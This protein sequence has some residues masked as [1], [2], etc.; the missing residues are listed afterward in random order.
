MPPL[1]TP[2]AER[3]ASPLDQLRRRSASLA[4]LPVPGQGRTAER[5]NALW[6]LGYVEL[7]LGRL[8]EAHA[9]SHAI[10]REAGRADLA[11]VDGAAA[12]FGVW[13]AEPPDGRVSIERDGPGW[14]LRG[15]KRWCSGAALLD[16]ALVTA[17]HGE[18]V[19]LVCVDLTRSGVTPHPPGEWATPALASAGTRSVDLDLSLDAGALVGPPGWY[20][21]RPGFWWGAAGVA[22]VW[23]G[24]AAGLLAHLLPR[25]RHDPISLAHLGAAHAGVEAARAT[26]MAVA[27]AIDAAPEM[28]AEEAARLAYN[29]RHVADLTAGEVID[30]A[31]RALGPA[32]LAQDPEISQ[33]MADLAL[34]VRQ[35]HAERDLAALGSLVM[36]RVDPVAG[37]GGAP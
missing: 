30:H 13:A 4:A 17:R 12:L 16:R 22:A 10:L 7:S 9:D 26:A 32:P 25:W 31:T 36:A 24:G 33:R 37:E 6:D 35:A 19:Q 2:E 11:L 34:Y 15:T 5:F 8:G 29:T 23:A 18:A 28:T 1:D 21:S 20:L 3:G 14:R 27:R